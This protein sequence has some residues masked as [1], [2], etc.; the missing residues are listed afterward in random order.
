LALAGIDLPLR[1]CRAAASEPDIDTLEVQAAFQSV[2][3]G[4]LDELLQAGEALAH[5]TP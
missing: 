3:A 1:Q 5:E 4:A 2:A